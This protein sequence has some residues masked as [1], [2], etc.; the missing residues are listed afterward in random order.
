MEDG[1]RG[2][3]GGSWLPNDRLQDLCLLG[4]DNRAVLDHVNYHALALQGEVTSLVQQ[5]LSALT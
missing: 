3:G 1:L 4:S 2:W 5:L